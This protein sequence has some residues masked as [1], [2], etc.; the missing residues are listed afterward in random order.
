MAQDKKKVI[1]YADWIDKFEELTDDEAGKLIKHFFRYIND[2][3]PEAPD[4]TTKLLFIDIQNTLKRDLLKWE[5][6]LDEK[7]I[8][9]RIGNLKRYNEDVYNDFKAK[10][11]TLEQAEEIAKTRK[12]SLSDKETRTATKNIANLA[13]NVSDSDSV[14]D[15]VIK[16][17]NIDSR[18]LKFANTLI[19]FVEIYG[20]D[21]IKDFYE[22]WTEPN[23]SNTKYK[24]ELLKTWS[25]ERRLATWAKNDNNFNK[26]KNGTTKITDTEEFKHLI[27]SIRST[28]ERI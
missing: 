12:V 3:N 20:R 7:S 18:K 23:K 4:R 16:T 17:N 11:I 21:M 27:T 24:Q 22:Y 13:D 8:N 14:N 10:K 25:L 6:T 19:P 26:Q 15:I 5:A 28:G 9:G 1:V 2:L